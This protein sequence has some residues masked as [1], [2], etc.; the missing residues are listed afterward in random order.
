MPTG[1][2]RNQLIEQTQSDYLTFIDDD[3]AV[4]SD[5]VSSILEAMQSNP[6]VITFNG[7]VTTDGANKKELTYKS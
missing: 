6:D 3:D 4:S 7:F 1:T 5:Y 2:K